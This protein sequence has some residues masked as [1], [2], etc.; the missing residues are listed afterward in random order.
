MLPRQGIRRSYCSTVAIP[1]LVTVTVVGFV[2]PSVAGMS[3]PGRRD[4]E[5]LRDCMRQDA[6]ALAGFL[7]DVALR[8]ELGWQRR[9]DT[10]LEPKF[11]RARNG[12]RRAR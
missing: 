5:L 7:D 1:A 3:A 8:A 10:R 9:S 12:C 11:T 6:L 4:L 2:E